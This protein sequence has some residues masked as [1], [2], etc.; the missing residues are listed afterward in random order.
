MAKGA[1]LLKAKAKALSV[2]N[3]RG[4]Y[5]VSGLLGRC[6]GGYG[7]SGLLGKCASGTDLKKCVSFFKHYES[8]SRDRL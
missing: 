3:N 8:H 2:Q 4:G 6:A 1:V 5:G 7:V